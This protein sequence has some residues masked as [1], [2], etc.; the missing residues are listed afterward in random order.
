MVTDYWAVQYMHDPKMANEVEDEEFDLDDV[1]KQMEDDD[2]Q[3]VE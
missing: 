2:W 3:V 1:L